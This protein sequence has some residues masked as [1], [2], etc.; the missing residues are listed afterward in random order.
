MKRLFFAM[1]LTMFVTGVSAQ[2]YTMKKNDKQKKEMKK[3]GEAD[4][5]TCMFNAGK[6]LKK[7]ANYDALS[8]GLA[9]ASVLAYTDVIDNRKTSNTIGTVLAIGSI[10]TRVCSINYKYKAGVELSISPGR[11]AVNF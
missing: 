11:L 7:S 5:H 3:T 1:L 6:Y 10:A 2:K 4:M 9:I 8:W